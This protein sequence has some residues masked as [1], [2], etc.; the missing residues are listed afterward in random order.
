MDDKE[1]G[2]AAQ[3]GSP[4]WHWDQLG[5]TVERLDRGAGREKL[6]VIRDPVGMVVLH[7]AGYDGEMEY[8]KQL[9]ESP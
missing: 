6:R 4:N 2:M 9:I 1:D 3:P 7:D 8:I 5:Y